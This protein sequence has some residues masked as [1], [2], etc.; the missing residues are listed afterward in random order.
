MNTQNSKKLVE[1]QEKYNAG[2]KKLTAETEKRLQEM[3]A[4]ADTKVAEAQKKQKEADAKLNAKLEAE[5]KEQER[6]AKA[7]EQKR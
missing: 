3:Q 4:L 6:I 1:M 2:M 5:R 7:E